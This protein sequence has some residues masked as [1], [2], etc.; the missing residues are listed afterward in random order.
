[1]SN[2]FTPRTGNT[3][4]PP[5]GGINALLS[6]PLVIIGAVVVAVFGGLA[7]LMGS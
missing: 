4:R 2:I 3:P 5:S 6:L 1:M 7:G